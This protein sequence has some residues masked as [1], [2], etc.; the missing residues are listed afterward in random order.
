MRTAVSRLLLVALV[1]VG[2][3]AAVRLGGGAS[4]VIAFDGVKAEEL[5]HRALDLD[6]PGR[7]AIDAAGSFEEVA[8]EAS[9]TT[10]AA[11]AWIVRRAD[12][13][14]VWRMRPPRP[15]RGTL[16]SVRD[17]V[18]LG[19]G[20]YDVYF[21]SFGDP[22]VRAP[23]PRDGSLRERL[24][25]ALSR[26]GR[27]W[28]GDSGRWRFIL[29]GLDAP[30]RAAVTRSDEGR[31]HTSSEVDSA[32]VWAAYEVRSRQ[33]R[34]RLVQVTDSVRVRVRVFT[35]VTDGVVADPA[36][37]VRL[38]DG[39]TL[40]TVRPEAGVWAGGSLKNR[41]LTEEVALAPGLYRLAYEADRSHAYRD[42]EANPPFLPWAWGMEIRSLGPPGAVVPIDPA[43]LDLPR[44]TGFNCVGPDEEREDMFIVQE[45][46]DVLVVA[47]GEVTGGSRYDYGGLDRLDEHDW[48]EVWEM[49]RRGLDRAGGADKNR[50]DVEALSLEP[51]TYRLRYET[52]GSHDCVSGYNN[53][54]GPDE[55]FWGAAL[56]ALDPSFDLDAVIRVAAPTPGA[57]YE[58]PGPSLARIDSVGNNENRRTT[59]V[60]D[61]P[62]EV[63]VVAAGEI[64]ESSRYDYATLRDDAGRVVWEMTRRNTAHAGGSL[65]NRRFEGRLALPAGRYTVEYQTDGSVAF[66][67]Y[68]TDG[69]TDPTLWG[70][71]VYLVEKIPEADAVPDAPS[72][73]PEPPSLPA[74]EAETVTT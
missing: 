12:D 43:A 52:D 1:G 62:G 30:A 20:I 38:G 18:T 10:M 21:A 31:L 5:R 64:S 69:P 50:R 51:G 33:R 54:G 41:R 44:I 57:R 58:P 53:G 6:A 74:P 70:V 65:R 40:W 60:L 42:W 15:E 37:I 55:P 72:A 32:L 9:D 3:A 48:D 19:A 29:S 26:G 11:T 7:F 2:I 47:V 4:G 39:D 22:L 34:Q 56:Y 49:E 46:A 71:R 16:V 17:T 63:F 73:P 45:A 61:E 14:V 13:A 23:G 68:A 35:E 27:A 8:T 66:G 36:S 59:F 67:D 28:L 25:S 24:R